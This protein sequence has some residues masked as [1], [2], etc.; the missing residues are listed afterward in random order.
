MRLL[1]TTNWWS[2][3]QNTWQYL[4]L[5]LPSLISTKCEG[6]I[7]FHKWRLTVFLTLTIHTYFLPSTNLTSW[8]R[9]WNM[10]NI[11][12]DCNK[13]YC[14]AIQPSWY[15]PSKIVSYIVLK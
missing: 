10:S 1:W 4:N 5:S 15:F 3:V 2:V 8:L 13:T 14:P 11:V 12:S 6:K 9:I 7:L